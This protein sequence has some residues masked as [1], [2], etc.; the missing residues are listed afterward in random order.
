MGARIL[1][2]DAQ[3]RSG[4]VVL[5]PDTTVYIGRALDCAVRTDD[6]MVSRKHS[7]VKM[8]GGRFLVEDLGSSNGTHVNDVKVSRQVLNHNDV[9]R[10][11]NLWLRYIEDAPAEGPPEP[12]APAPMPASS[13]NKFRETLGMPGNGRATD[14]TFDAGTGMPPPLM[15]PSPTRPS[16]PPS[17]PPPP[18]AREPSG[19]GAAASVPVASSGSGSGGSAGET[20]VRRDDGRALPSA[21]TTAPPS[22]DLV[23]PAAKMFSRNSAPID[24]PTPPANTPRPP[25]SPPP[26]FSS[27]GPAS[28]EAGPTP[29]GD[30]ADPNELRRRLLI[31]T[32]RAA[33]IERSLR[34]L[35]AELEAA[36]VKIRALLEGVRELIELKP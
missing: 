29:A 10:C 2:R 18:M 23:P 14:D 30:A 36:Q 9:V 15:S 31:A 16:P 24:G 25:L 7:L 32:S 26:G 17:V 35:S 5:V 28:W 13:S 12:S 21:P 19:R 34:T 4:E 20:I 3:G 27:R 8:E 6:A 1:F 33:E 22:A 11:G